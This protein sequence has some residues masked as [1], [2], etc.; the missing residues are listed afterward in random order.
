[1]PPTRCEPHVPVLTSVLS[2]GRL[3]TAMW[4][5]IKRVLAPQVAREV[6]QDLYGH[7]E[8]LGDNKNPQPTQLSADISSMS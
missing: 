7:P 5:S 1:M 8:S 2:T 4:K 6:L 3:Q